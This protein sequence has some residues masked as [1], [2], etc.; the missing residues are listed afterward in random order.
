[1]KGEGDGGRRTRE[2]RGG[3]VQGLGQFTFTEDLQGHL[4]VPDQALGG[5]DGD[6]DVVPVLEVRLERTHVEHVV[7][8]TEEA[9][10]ESSLGKPTGPW[11]LATFE[12][13][14]MAVT[15]TRA[16]TLVSTTTGLARA[17]AVASTDSF[18]GLVSTRRFGYVMNHHGIDALRLVAV[19]F[20][21]SSAAAVSSVG[22]SVESDF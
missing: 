3:D 8:G 6:I 7:V 5:Q 17:A 15:G 16:G 11:H 2:L 4:G 20:P 10:A 21:V 9:V 18:P 1:M 14:S 12:P 13:G 22:S 19:Q